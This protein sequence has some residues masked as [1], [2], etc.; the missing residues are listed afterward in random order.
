M[1]D[2]SSGALYGTALPS[3]A[4]NNA[5]EA[6]GYVVEC[7]LNVISELGYRDVVLHTDGEPSIVALAEKA[8]EKRGRGRTLLEQG[9]RYSHQSQG[10]VEQGIKALE[11][12]CRTLLH[13]LA[14]RTGFEY[15]SKHPIVAWAVRHSGF[16]LT[17]FRV[18]EHGRTPLKVL[19][20]RDYSGRSSSLVSSV[21]GATPRPGRIRAS[22]R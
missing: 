15:D 3:K 17:N 20:G 16:L 6:A 14:E 7:V 13:Y 19:R 12:Q 4:T 2:C 18:L 5:S 21:G 10:P 11:G 1:A 9:P 8:K 22:S